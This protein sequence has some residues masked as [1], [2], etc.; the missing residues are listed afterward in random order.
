MTAPMAYF[1]ASVVT[2]VGSS[3]SKDQRTGTEHKAFFSDSNAFWCSSLH[4]NGA[5]LANLVK[6]LAI[7]EQS[8][9]N[10]L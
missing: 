3:G 5:L 4:S 10:L 2:A 1:E 8:L 6:G 7:L 9:L